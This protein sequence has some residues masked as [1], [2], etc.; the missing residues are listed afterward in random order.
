M[1]FYSSWLC[2]KN[3]IW[4]NFVYHLEDLFNGRSCLVR[5]GPFHVSEWGPHGLLALLIQL[6]K[7]RSLVINTVIGT[8]ILQS[9]KSGLFN[10]TVI[11]FRTISF[12]C[13][14]LKTSPTNP[15][16]LLGDFLTKS[17]QQSIRLTSNL[18]LYWECLRLYILPHWLNR[19]WSRRRW[20]E[21]PN[22]PPR[23]LD[24]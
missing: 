8:T 15:D 18:L 20:E 5:I 12:F 2:S 24:T 22:L 17:P 11:Y 13:W 4:S 21:Q 7:K 3:N 9:H 14:P 16:V 10:N 23:Q 1:F 6:K 19:P